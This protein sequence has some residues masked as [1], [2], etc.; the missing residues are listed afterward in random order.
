[1]FTIGE[2]STITGLTVKT[3][4]FYHER[5]L[6]VPARVDAGTGYRYY[7]EQNAETAR[8]I[9][10]LRDLQVPLDEVATILERCSSD[11]E[12]STYLR[13][14][15]ETIAQQ[16][17]HYRGL[18]KQVDLFLKQHHQHK[19]IEMDNR[20]SYE[21]E[22]KTVGA[23]LIAA[24]RMK[25]RYSDC[26]EGFARLGR[27]V[28]R[29]IAGK[30]MCLMHDGEYRE[31]DAEFEVAFPIRKAVEIDGIDV[32]ELTE[33]DCVTLVH[34]GPY[35]TLGQTYERLLTHAKQE[36]YTIQLPTREVYLKGPGMI[37]KGNPKHYLTEVQL[38]VTAARDGG[39][40]TGKRIT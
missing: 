23:L 8:A 9:K 20:Q 31:D 21:I 28:G 35:N 26:G 10:A 6:L 12:V 1:M 32:R 13:Q 5:G 37:L 3:L 33:V 2:F 38:P 18:I 27:K 25:G 11:E 17:A 30:P 14:H 39:A 7:D 24:I 4:R 36:Q 16:L 15:R 34:R 19:D 22:E 40:N 29:L